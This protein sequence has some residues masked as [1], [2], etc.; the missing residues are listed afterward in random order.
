MK[1]EN[2]VIYARVDIG[3]REEGLPLLYGMGFEPRAKAQ[4]LHPHLYV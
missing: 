4:T 3:W 1:D 2:L